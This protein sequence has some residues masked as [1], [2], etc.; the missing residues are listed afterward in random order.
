VSTCSSSGGRRR[1]TVHDQLGR[2]VVLGV[3]VHALREP[4]IDL[5][6]GATTELGPNQ[7]GDFNLGLLAD[8]G[9]EVTDWKGVRYRREA[10]I[11]VH[12]LP[13]HFG[14][15]V[16]PD[17][18]APRWD[19][20]RVAPGD[21]DRTSTSVVAHG[22]VDHSRR[23]AWREERSFSKGLGFDGYSLLTSADCLP[24]GPFASTCVMSE[25][26]SAGPG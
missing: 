7:P 17:H 6:Q 12:T 9:T 15:C 19:N 26:Q 13:V 11:D 25:G 2:E 20:S 18:S 24:R 4:G 21:G 10:E 5:A 8:A 23:G 16:L 22:R 1:S 14:G 3:A